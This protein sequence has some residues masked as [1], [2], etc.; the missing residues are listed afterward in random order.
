[1]MYQDQA[2]SPT[3]QWSLGSRIISDDGEWLHMD[4]AGTEGQGLWI[5]WGG[6]A[7]KEDGAWLAWGESADE[8]SGYWASWGNDGGSGGWVSWGSNDWSGGRGGGGGGA[9][10]RRSRM[11]AAGELRLALLHF[12]SG[13]SRH[14]YELIKA[15]E[16]L[17][18]GGYAPSPGAVYP[19][20]NLMVDEGVI[21]EAESEGA[22]KNFEITKEGKSE[23]DVRK[24]EVD[25]LIAKLAAKSEG[26]AQE[27]A[28]DL[29]RA[30]GNLTT[31]LRNRARNGGME[32]EAVEEIVDLIDELSR[33]IER[34]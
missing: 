11:F 27:Q 9:R 22:R 16:E 10:S 33:R 3:S 1:M 14:G 17:T 31:V 25:A 5:S 26:V 6:H 24:G 23:L 7:D 15:I 34:L 8:K 28:P 12:I 30:M 19:T 13:Q 2:V 18:G 32:K 29:F 21:K 20:L 4:D